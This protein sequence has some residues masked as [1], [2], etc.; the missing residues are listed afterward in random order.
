MSHTTISGIELEN[1]GELELAPRL[2]TLIRS[3]EMISPGS[4]FRKARVLVARLLRK[5]QVV[6]PPHVVNSIERSHE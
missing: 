4:T 5:G 6:H 3:P 1:F 2:E